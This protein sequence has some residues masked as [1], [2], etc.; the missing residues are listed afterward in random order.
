MWCC[1]YFT[2]KFL[3]KKMHNNRLFI[4][5]L[6][7][8]VLS[9][10]SLSAQIL[11]VEKERLL[12]DSANYWVLNLGTSVSLYNRSALDDA[13]LRYT[14]VRG[15]LDVL[16][17]GKKHLY[18]LLNQYSYLKIND[19]EFFNFGYTHLRSNLFWQRTLSYELFAQWQVD[20]LR[21]LQE[22]Y[23]GG[24]GIRWRLLD[25]PQHHVFVG[26]GLMA[27]KEVWLLNDDTTQYTANPFFWKSSNYVHW[28]GQITPTVKT[29]MAIYYQT[30]YDESINNFRH[31]LSGEI[32]LNFPVS[33][34]LKFNT[35]FTASYE[36][37]PL[38][39]ITPFIYQF[40]QGL[41]LSL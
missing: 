37:L 40:S 17:A 30:G 26:L 10:V 14:S 22:R 35:S 36:S 23:L 41:T 32:H 28:R 4:C 8:L 3:P 16:R 39:P 24:G 9:G 5:L 31:R 11:N 33:K 25:T 1:K 12:P 18:L 20:K 34:K 6:V 29:V 19:A 38:I 15:N 7:E 2:K 21:G 27:E 13:P